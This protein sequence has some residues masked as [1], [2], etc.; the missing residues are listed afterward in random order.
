[1]DERSK[2]VFFSFAVSIILLLF[3][4]IHLAAGET[5]NG[6]GLGEGR[7][8]IRCV[9]PSSA[10]PGKPPEKFLP[11]AFRLRFYIFIFRSVVYSFFVLEISISGK[12][13]GKMSLPPNVTGI[14]PAFP[15]P[16]GC[17]RTSRQ[18]LRFNGA[19]YLPARPPRFSRCRPKRPSAFPVDGAVPH[20][21][22]HAAFPSFANK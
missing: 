17:P 4:I 14:G 19:R 10:S 20:G 13:F 12:Y 15:T 6:G 22:L 7:R 1:M 11:P 5:K 18:I 9:A 16:S 21:V 3:G 2:S 8:G